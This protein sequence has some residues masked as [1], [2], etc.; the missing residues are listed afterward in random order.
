MVC[1]GPDGQIPPPLP[2]SSRRFF[3]AFPILWEGSLPR[4][5][6][7]LVAMLG[8]V[9]AP[10]TVPVLS[11]LGRASGRPPQSE[12]WPPSPAWGCS[13][14]VLAWL[15]AWGHSPTRSWLVCSFVVL[16]PTHSHPR[17]DGHP[18]PGWLW[19]GTRDGDVTF[20]QGM[21]LA[22]LGQSTVP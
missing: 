19:E 11:S 22:A 15:R 18:P 13:G 20:A 10:L 12:L 7:A 6:S 14:K 1:A 3:P 17:T 2:Q 5:H 9:G 21:C 4:C 16:S 8:Q